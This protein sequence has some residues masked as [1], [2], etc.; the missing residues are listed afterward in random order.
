MMKVLA[1]VL[2]ALLAVAA[3]LVL[4]GQLGFLSGKP[5]TDLGVRDGRLKPPSATPNSVSSQADWFPEHPQRSYAAIAPLA[6]VGDADQ[7]MQK[8]AA[9]LKSSAGTVLVT[10]QPD[11][12]YAQCSTPWL[13]F[14]DDV[15]FWLDRKAGVIQLR[16]ASRLGHGDLGANRARMEKIRAQF[17]S[18]N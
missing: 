9:I 6:F 11:Y 5:P 15:E 8:L 2:V 10:Q 18:Q 7:A 13:H 12:L 3:A 1:Y 17:L 14:T 16:S 4:A